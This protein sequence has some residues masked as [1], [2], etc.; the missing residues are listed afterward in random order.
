M[1]ILLDEN[2]PFDFAFAKLIFEPEVT[3][4]H[5]IALVGR[6]LKT[7]NCFVVRPLYATCLS[8]LIET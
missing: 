5:V 4:L 8:P 2:I 1:R 3:T 7:V 6:D